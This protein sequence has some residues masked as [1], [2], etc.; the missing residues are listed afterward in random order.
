[1][2]RILYLI[3]TWLC[4]VP[5]FGM[6]IAE[7]F[8]PL[9]WLS[10]WFIVF[11]P[12]LV[13]G[14]RSVKRRINDNSKIKL[15]YAVAGAFVF[16]LSS[17]KLPS[18]GGS[19]SH[20]TGIALGAILFGASGMSVIGLVTL[21]FQALL[22]AHGGLT[23]LGANAFSMAVVGAFVAVWI[24]QFGKRMRLPQNIIV[25]VAALCSNISIYI[26]T[27]FQ[28]AAAFHSDS[29]TIIENMVK[30]MSV[31]MVA[32]LPLAIIEGLL[33]IVLFNLILKYN[34]QELKLLNPQI[35]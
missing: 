18:L 29:S 6:H 26:C 23:T 1:M 21:L 24:F 22:L 31:F 12:F 8:L 16:V 30:F 9:K 3:V 14:Y 4:S 10:I 15:L 13:S 19:S 7:G 27:S 34:K 28:L 33:T 25:F 20:L 35:Q 11:I 5:V 17:L 32:Q 2:R